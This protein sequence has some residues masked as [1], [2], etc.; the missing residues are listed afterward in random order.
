MT[1]SLPRFFTP[2]RVRYYETDLQG[3]VNFIWHQSY[4][5]I[6]AADYLKAVGLSYEALSE[7]GFDLL[8]VDVHGTFLGPCFYD[9]ILHVHCRL[10]KIGNSSLR[11]AFDTRADNGA[12]A[13]ASGDLTAVLVDK[14][15]R[16]KTTVPDFFRAAVKAY[17]NGE[18]A[19]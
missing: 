7:K 2:I 5:A 6:A 10:E 13:V 11:F 3:H 15:T 12:R 4:F 16:K 8:F 9:E 18:I 1:E 14:N 17:E 19:E